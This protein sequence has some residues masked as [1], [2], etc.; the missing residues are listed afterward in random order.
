MK[1]FSLDF[2]LD[3]GK[4]TKDRRDYRDDDI[5]EIPNSRFFS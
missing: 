3:L 4:K 1:M 5:K 2:T